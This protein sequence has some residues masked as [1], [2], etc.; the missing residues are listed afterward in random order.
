MRILNYLVKVLLLGNVVCADY[1]DI[2]PYR[3]TDLG[4]TQ[5]I[6]ESLP[7]FLDSAVGFVVSIHQ[8][9]RINHD[10][11]IGGGIAAVAISTTAIGE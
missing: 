4:P 3:K 6:N 7:I 10:L 9:H 1:I 2:C 11:Q 5:I 8:P